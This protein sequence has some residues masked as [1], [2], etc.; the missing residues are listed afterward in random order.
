MKVRKRLKLKQIDIL[1]FGHLRCSNNI[2]YLSSDET[3][4]NDLMIGEDV[5]KIKNV[6][7]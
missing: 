5:E 1:E 7:Y 2:T 4:S 6:S 3:A